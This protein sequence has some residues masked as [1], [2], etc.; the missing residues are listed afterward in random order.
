MAPPGAEEGLTEH[1]SA[2]RHAALRCAAQLPAAAD[3][4]QRA[5]MPHRPTHAPARAA[6]RRPALLTR[7]ARRTCPSALPTST[8][9]RDQP[10]SPLPA[11]AR[12]ARARCG[13]ASA[14]SERSPPPRRDRRIAAF[15]SIYSVI[16]YQDVLR[17][18]HFGRGIPSNF[19][20]K[21]KKRSFLSCRVCV[22]AQVA[23]GCEKARTAGAQL[24]LH[25]LERRR[26]QRLSFAIWAVIGGQGVELQPLLDS[27][28]TSERLRMALLRMR[29][30]MREIST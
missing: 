4:T 27:S 29:D 13:A 12:G 11:A 8:R 23:C 10:P 14:R 22:R 26:A 20:A 16:S 15:A 25:L 5:H 28:S 30:V 24:A 21:K 3:R 9:R 7:R 6:P 1:G 18:A 2:P 17:I 19:R